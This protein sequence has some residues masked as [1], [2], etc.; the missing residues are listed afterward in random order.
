[1]SITYLRTSSSFAENSTSEYIAE[2]ATGHG[3]QP[4]TLKAL[5][6]YSGVGGWSLGLGMAGINVV[7]SYERAQ[8]A[9]R[10]ISQNQRTPVEP[11]DIRKLR[12]D[13]LPKGVSVVVGSPPCTQFSLSNKG[14][15]GDIADGLKDLG[16][17]LWAVDQLRPRYWV[18]ENV[19]RVKSI[20]ED[21]VFMRTGTLRRFRHLFRHRDVHIEIIDMSDF[22]LPQRRL[23]CL[24]GRFPLGLLRRYAAHCPARTLA[25]VLDALDSETPCDPLY[26]FQIPRDQLIDHEFE[27]PLTPEE[28]RLNRDAK[29][30]HPVYNRMAFPDRI[31]RPVRAITATCTRVSRESVVIESPSNPGTYR[32]LTLRERACA[33]GFPITYQFYGESYTGKMELIGNAI[34]PLFSYYIGC[35]IRGMSELDLKHPDKTGYQ[36]LA[37]VQRPCITSN[38]FGIARYLEARRFRAVVPCLRF[39]SGVRF[40]LANHFQADRVR[41]NISFFFGTSS[42]IRQLHL[43]QSMAKRMHALVAEWRLKTFIERSLRIVRQSPAY[44]RAALLQSRWSRRAV[45]PGPYVLLQAIDVLT[46]AVFAASSALSISSGEIVMSGLAVGSIIR[47]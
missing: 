41:W 28:Q 8:T 2:G 18:L 21:H 42:D 6:L 40:E 4:S 29:R 22:G 1:M 25:D 46:R 32:R 5:D 15:N 23:R 47:R 38:Q 9:C 34:P 3:I 26:G 43:N 24:A 14:G 36:H 7:A 10:T 19:P 12:R 20:L 39:K 45:G 11:Q 44:C 13:D 17:F 16:R 31:G 33:Q 30:A 37:P 35:A 27:T